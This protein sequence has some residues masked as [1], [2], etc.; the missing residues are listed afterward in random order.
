VHTLAQIEDAI[1]AS[2]DRD[3]A[4][5]DDGWTPE[6]PTANIPGS[7]A[8]RRTSSSRVAFRNTSPEIT[9]R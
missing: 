4:D 3:T 5:K 1:R 8:T 9:G 6:N 7:T 2:W